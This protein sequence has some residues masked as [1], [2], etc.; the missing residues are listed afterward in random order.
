MFVFCFAGYIDDRDT[1]L[2]PNI[3]HHIRQKFE[4]APRVSDHTPASAAQNPNTSWPTPG[5]GGVGKLRACKSCKTPSLDALDFQSP[6][7]NA[8]RRFSPVR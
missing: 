5:V 8:S 3:S 7:D 4:A 6:S 2:E 1:L